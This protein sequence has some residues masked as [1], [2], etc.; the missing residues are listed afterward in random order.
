MLW[1]F[2]VSD[3]LQRFTKRARNVLSL[4]Q[5]EAKRLRHNEIGTEHLLLGLLLEEGGMGGRVLRELGLEQARVQ[6]MIEQ[7]RGPAQDAP[8]AKMELALGTKRALELAIKE[9]RQ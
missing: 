5:K 4:A 7:L 3:K 8:P 1:R 9:A 2:S 6:D